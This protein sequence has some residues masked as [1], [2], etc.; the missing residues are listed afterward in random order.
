MP[1]KQVLGLTKDESKRYFDA[2]LDE[3]NR[4]ALQDKRK[5]GREKKK[6]LKLQKYVMGLADSEPGRQFGY[7]PS[8]MMAGE[9]F[10]P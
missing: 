6:A 9:Y 2:L 1:Q 4:V 7:G 8:D 5:E 3:E 10:V